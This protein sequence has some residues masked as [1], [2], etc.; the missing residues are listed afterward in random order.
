MQKIGMACEGTMQ[1]K[2]FNKGAYR[3][4][5]EDILSLVRQ[6]TLE[7]KASLLSGLDNWHTKPL[8]RLGIPS[9]LMTDGPHGLRL[10]ATPTG[11]P[12]PATC[13]PT[14]VGLASSWNTR[15]LEKIGQAIGDECR[16][17]DVGVL[18]GPAINIK[19]SPLC[20]RNFEYYSEDPFLAGS[21]AA[22]FVQGVQSRGVGAC[23]KHFALNNMETRR[24]NNDS[25]CDMRT[26]REIYLAAFEK[27][28]TESRPWTM[29]CSYNRINGVFASD[30]KLLMT[31]ILREEWGFDGF[32]MTDW[33]ALND[34]IAAIK[35]GVE[36]EMPASDGTTDRATADAVR[37]GQL[38]ESLLDRA[39]E[40]YLEVVRRADKEIG[41]ASCRE[42]V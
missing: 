11:V 42:R 4:M 5:K 40:R 9:L 35:A 39:V 25:V 19:R 12:A 41:R 34:R 20:G 33:G 13:F 28:V 22:S 21:L 36:L 2:Y 10:N 14:A 1:D 26:M 24:Q 16:T 17:H 8:E 37:T 29:M 23:L 15:L 3:T 27:A 32:V 38:D 7:E 6:M 31:D 30:N 18:L